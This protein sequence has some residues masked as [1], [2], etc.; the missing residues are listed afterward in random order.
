MSKITQLTEATN[1]SSGDDLVEIVIDTATTP[2]NRKMKFLNLL[3]RVFL[4][5]GTQ[6]TVTTIADGEFLK[7]SGTN[8]LGASPG[9]GGLGDVVGPASA[10]DEAVARYDTTT[11]KLIQNSAVL[12]N[13]DGAVTVPEVA[14]PATP[15]T[16]KVVLYAK[17]DGL[18][19]S[20]DDA[21]TESAVSGGGGATI[22]PTDNVLPR[23]S[24]S[25]TFAD[26]FL[27]HDAGN[28]KTHTT[29]HFALDQNT[30]RVLGFANSGS[31]IAFGG[32]AAAGT[33]AIKVVADA[34]GNP[35]TILSVFV[36]PAEPGGNPAPWSSVG[37]NFRRVL[38]GNISI[39]NPGQTGGNGTAID[40]Y[41]F[42]LMLVQD[43]TGS[44]TA[45]WGSD[46]NFP[47]GTTPTLTTAADAVDIFEFICYGDQ[48]YCIG[49]WLDVK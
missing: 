31:A 5:D 10:T 39:G 2:V 41:R 48:A 21:G 45:T 27:T 44:R 11:G 49:Q 9:G 23:R 3:R 20:K 29:G 32:L 8:I 34:G 24:N 14:A 16:G 35:G 25:T 28:S 4:G 6:L 40:G 43:G 17:T 33:G 15:A 46:Y 47:G 12:I 1:P 38:T 7:R 36:A 19:Y 13:N 18:L 30:N 26:S 42:I 37:M 22:N